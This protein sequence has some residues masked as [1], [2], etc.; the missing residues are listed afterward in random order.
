MVQTDGKVLALIAAAVTAGAYRELA[1][2][3]PEHPGFEKMAAKWTA[4]GAQLCE[5]IGESGAGGSP[6]S[7]AAGVAPRRRNR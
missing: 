6:P 1:R 3:F 4:M 7:P 5:E 2:E